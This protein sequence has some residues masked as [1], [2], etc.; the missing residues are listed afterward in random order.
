MPVSPSPSARS[1]A[2]RLFHNR[3]FA[4]LWIGQ[5]ISSTGDYF[6]LLAIPIFVNRLTG[7]VMLVG[8]SFLSVALPA[9]VLGPVAGVFVDRLDRRKVMIISDVL[10]GLL[11][12]VLL[13]VRDASQVWIVYLVGLLVSCAAQF[14]SPARGAVLPLIVPGRDDWLSANAAMRI[15]QTVGMLAGPA[16]AGAAIGLW[17]ERAA[18]IADGASFLVSAAAVALMAIPRTTPGLAGEA[19]SVRSV[20]ADLSEGLAYMVSNRSTLG[21]FICMGMASLGYSTVNMI[22]IPFLQR[23]Y[24]VGAAGIGIADAAL[25]AGM[26]AGGLLAG[27]VAAHLS[28][29]VISAGGLAFDGLMYIAILLLPS[30]PWVIPWQFL[31]GLSLTPMQSALDTIF[32]LA[33]PDLKRGRVG[34][35]LS[36]SYNAAGMLS[37]A[38]ATLFADAIGL[39]SIFAIVGGCVLASGLL[40]FWLIKEPD[41][42]LTADVLRP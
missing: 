19:S 16:L 1:P 22:W 29:P 3:N 6:T 24:G 42:A 17:G 30:F 38:F 4:A 13:T 31:A 21:I 20:W 33:V 25:G 10:R 41:G 23:E 12:L 11:T 18:F 15:I 32:Q 34:A 2:Q 39:R 5:A 40:G 28:K 37:M 35:S 26:L 8:L 36:A 27:Q 7:S 14:F 9:L